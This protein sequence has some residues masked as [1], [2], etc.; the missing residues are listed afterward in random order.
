MDERL[1]FLINQRWTGPL[2]DRVMAAASALDVWLPFI[3]A[4]V[5]IVAWRGRRR[6]RLFLVALGLILALGDGVVSN[7]LKHRVHRL[8]PFQAVAGVRQVDLARKVQPR[9]LALFR[10]PVVNR[11][12]T[13]LPPPDPTGG[14]SFPSSHTV[15]NFC[16]AVL[17]TLFYRWRG[18]L[19]F[20]PA[21]LV[22]YS[23]VYV[24]SHWPSDVLIS[25]ALGLGLALTAM[26]TFQAAVDR[27]PDLASFLD[28]RP[29]A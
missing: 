5:A 16:A 26:A 20:L 4:L 19:Y 28:S 14:R 6:A 3:V 18:A 11:T 10:P 1:Q 24:G 2:L 23:R 17:L 9:F 13:P 15:N 25:A 21:V 27:W 22:G 7:N 29:S 12:T 8:R